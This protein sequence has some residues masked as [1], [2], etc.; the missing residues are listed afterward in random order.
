[1]ELASELTKSLA[2]LGQNS[3]KELASIY[4]TS[5]LAKAQS[6]SIS[7]DI[8]IYISCPQSSE[9]VREEEAE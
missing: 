6:I 8:Y 5:Q 4:T 2:E 3:V 1:M 7:G 9:T